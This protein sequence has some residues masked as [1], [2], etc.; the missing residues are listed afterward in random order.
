MKYNITQYDKD[1][2]T[3][4]SVDYRYRLFI[5]GKDKNILDELYG[6]QSIGTYT[7]DSQSDARRTASIT[8]YLDDRYR[9][10]SIENKLADWIGCDFELQ[11]GLYSIREDDY[12]W[13]KCGYYLITEANTAYNAAD[14]SISLSLSDWY[15]KLNGTRNGQIGGA[16]II[17]IPNEDEKGRPVTIKQATEALVKNETDIQD[18]II[19]DIG[20]FYGIPQNNPD[21]EQY[22]SENPLWNQLPYDLEY[23]AGCTIGDIFSEINNLYPNCQMYFDIYGNFC[24]HQIP[25]CEYDPVLLN[26]NF[27]QKI[28]VAEDSENVSY[29]VAGI[30]NVTE[31]F[32]ADYEI[33]R[34]SSSC[35]TANATYLLTLDDYTNYASGNI[36]AFIPDSANTSGMK[37]RINSLD[38]IPLYYEYS[39]VPVQESLLEAEKTYVLQIKKLNGNYVAYYMGQYQPHALCVL[40]GDENDGQ[41]TKAYFS[42]KY[43]CSER[44]IT[45]RVEPESPFTVQRLGEILDVKSGDEFENIISDSVALE[46]AVYYNKK[47]SSVN[48][49]VT[50]TTKMIPFLDA[51]IKIEYKKQQ[52]D[53]PH[54]YIITSVSNN[55]ESLVSQITMCRFY[56]LYYI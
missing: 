29:D 26:N 52:E 8:M 46:N 9:S 34:Y 19:E 42:Q 31:V 22:R 41:Y 36:I 38:P 3:Q 11:I 44:N 5:V 33:D 25:S 54:H 1:L 10:D 16:P 4:E 56:P 18:Y 35:S 48:D 49:T 27:L 30:K 2:L 28:L 51:N 47:S 39:A 21:Y 24:F 12:I 13:Y 50:I 15:S 23:E 45:L 55:T 43:N 40:T 37:I 17:S 7:V 53:E 14:N 20:Q 32:G 6:V